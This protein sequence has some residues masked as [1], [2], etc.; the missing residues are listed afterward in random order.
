MMMS[1]EEEILSQW[2][3][4]MKYE[5]ICERMMNDDRLVR[6]CSPVGKRVVVMR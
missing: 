6:Y 5:S 2:K 1:R 4:T 3:Q